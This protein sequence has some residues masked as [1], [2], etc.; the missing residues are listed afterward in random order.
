MSLLPAGAGEHPQLSI[1][2]LPVIHDTS[3]FGQPASVVFTNWTYWSRVTLLLLSRLCCAWH[4]RKP[5][6]MMLLLS[7]THARP[8]LIYCS[9]L[10][11]CRMLPVTALQPI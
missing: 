11:N 2:A 9:T 7:N 4:T 8:C 1:N 3:I 10:V 6:A 5:D